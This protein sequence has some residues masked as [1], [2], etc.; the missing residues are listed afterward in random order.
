MNFNEFM[1]ALKFSNN[2][3]E[4]INNQLKQNIANNPMLNNVF[5]LVN[6]GNEK[7][8]RILAENLCKERGIDINALEKQIISNIKQK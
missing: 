7:Q 4:I 1:N 8:L 6:T 5:N 3:N 2:P